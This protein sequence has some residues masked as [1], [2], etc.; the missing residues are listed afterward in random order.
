[1]GYCSSEAP[2]SHGRYFLR[3]DTKSTFVHVVEFNGNLDL[4]VWTL[5]IYAYTYDL[6]FE[7]CVVS[8]LSILLLS[9]DLN[10][11]VLTL[12]LSQKKKKHH[13]GVEL[14]STDSKSNVLTA[15]PRCLILLKLLCMLYTIIKMHNVRDFNCTL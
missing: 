13:A 11:E 1:M 12:S 3:S 6:R 7:N 8:V 5:V 2:P 9:I 10:N 4:K 14:G 15:T